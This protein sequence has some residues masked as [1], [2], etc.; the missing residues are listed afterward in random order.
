MRWALAESARRALRAPLGAKSGK[1]A[2]IVIAGIAA[3]A[4]WIGLRD[5]ERAQKTVPSGVHRGP[6]AATLRAA[7]L[8]TIAS[9][10]ASGSSA[11]EADAEP[12][13]NG[14]AGNAERPATEDDYLRRLT[15]LDRTDKAAALAYAIRGDDWYDRT[16]RRAE[17][18]KARIV[19]LLVD[20]G[21]MEEARAATR[22]F[23]V[24]YPD[25]EYRPMV[26]GVTGIHPR[27]GRPG[28]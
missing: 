10:R 21:R 9:A 25:S 12:A 14:A 17:A 24:A 11:R 15:E 13:P 6:D 18:R 3:L 7:T 20:L 8:E 4:L 26:Q 22:A 5:E 23:L 2:S 27:P 1:A 16:G 28:E 19:T